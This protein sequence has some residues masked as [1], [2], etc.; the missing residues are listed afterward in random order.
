MKPK[1]QIPPPQLIVMGFALMILLGT[2]LLSLPVAVASGDFPNLIDSLF[3]A[4]SAVCV[5]G[6]MVVDTGTFYSPAGHVIILGLIQIGGLG[7]ITATSLYALLLGKRIGLRERVIMKHALNRDNLGGVVSMVR[8]IIMM[9]FAFELVGALALTIAFLKYFPP[10]EALW[11]GIFHA[12]SAFC[13]AGIDLFGAEFSGVSSLAPFQANQWVLAIVALLVV[14]GG[15]GFP[16]ILDLRT[17]RKWQHLSLHT[18]IALISTGGFVLLGGAFF[19]LFETVTAFHGMGAF[20]RM[21]N[22][23]FMG[24]VSRT[25]GFSTVNLN[26]AMPS[27]LILMM[28]MMF[29]GACPGG[30]GGGIKTTTFSVIVLATKARLQGKKDVVA[31]HRT[32][33]QESISLAYT[34]TVMSIAVLFLGMVLFSLADSHDLMALLFETFSALGTVGLSLGI[35][36]QLSVGGKI[37]IICL[38]FFGRLGPLTLALA[39]LERKVGV[40]KVKYPRDKVII[41]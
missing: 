30:T 33:D 29:V 35:T 20:D 38:M 24:V 11:Y 7:I 27:S 10:L 15:L 1:K 40:A 16:V 17:H 22:A 6:L 37:V 39:L 12:V 32:I 26:Q 14:I 21:V 19:F 4:T 3:T 9:T 28:F 36:S 8:S 13:N 41:G 25:A 34:V 2:I 31:F 5:T 18:K 23:L